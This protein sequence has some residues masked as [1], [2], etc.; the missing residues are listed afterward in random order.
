[1]KRL[2]LIIILAMCLCVSIATASFTNEWG[3]YQNDE[4]N[5]GFE[6]GIASHFTGIGTTYTV[7]AGMSYQPLAINMTGNDDLEIII[8]SGNYLQM[9]DEEL[10]LINELNVGSAIQSQPTI[11]NTPNGN[12]IVFFSEQV[13]YA[14]IYNTTDF[15]DQFSN[16]SEINIS[17]HACTTPIIR[18]VEDSY[19]YGLC[20]TT[21]NTYVY[22]INI[23]NGTWVESPALSPNVIRGVPAI[24]DLD[25]D[26]RNEIVIS[27]DANGNNDY[28]VCVFDVNT[29]N[30]IPYL[31]IDFN[32]DG[33]LDDID[34]VGRSGNPVIYNIDE[35]GY[36]ELIFSAARNGAP[37]NWDLT[38]YKSDGSV[39]WTATSTN[40]GVFY[41]NPIIMEYG[42]SSKPDVCAV[43]LDNNAA[44]EF[45]VF[46]SDYDG[47]IIVNT[48]I[49]G[50]SNGGSIGYN[51]FN[52]I[53]ATAINGILGDDGGEFDIVNSEYIIEIYD[54]FNVS[55]NLTKL[56]IS[57]TSYYTAYADVND[58]GEGDI[59]ISK[60]GTTKIIYSSF[61]NSP[62]TVDNTIDNGGFF[63]WPNPV[64]N[65]TTITFQ[66]QEC[67]GTADCN[68]ENDGSSDTERIATNC[69]IGT[70]GLSIESHVT[71]L[72]YG[73]YSGSNPQFDCYY[74]HTGF[75]TVRLFLQD[76]FNDDDFS[77]YNE[78]LISFNVIAGISGV[79]CNV[80]GSYVEEPS[81]ND[82]DES[83]TA[84]ET[85]TNDAVDST[86][87]LLFGTGSSSDKLKMLVGIAIVIG[88]IVM[89]AQAGI[90]NG[91]A[92]I[93]IGILG[94]IMVTFV[95]LLPSS[96][97]IL[98]LTAMTLLFF[99]G[100]AIMGS[101]NG[102]P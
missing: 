85:A 25:N 55:I 71:N 56:G 30:G 64:C 93:G 3:E 82:D 5:Q 41:S 24:D 81:D 57:D 12:A 39:K 101:D 78:N 58:D 77:E 42:N 23:T 47:S 63:G 45:N 13:L 40:V 83:T 27:C 16:A 51:G 14:Y 86:F 94:I 4:S 65:G 52:I 80:V 89:A 21:A 70:N 95:G 49:L 2:S 9:Y 73:N 46:C 22:K 19:C 68:Y 98:I 92:L 31:D 17:G 10:T 61:E 6:G 66:A 90:T 38:A 18:C 53:G 60:A 74:N 99:I 69:G 50:G 88:I 76:E 28:G 79:T 54:V 97:L 37:T 26:G 1:M 72:D 102:G 91:M 87:G 59:I 36:K 7:N 34:E 32:T 43:A 20:S 11:Y 75:M 48:Q 33:I 15:V 67:G 100:K 44:G 35:G 29:T 84:G 8:Y 96:L 62:P